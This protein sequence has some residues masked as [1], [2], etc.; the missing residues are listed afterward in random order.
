MAAVDGGGEK[1]IIGGIIAC[2]KP[3]NDV[4]ADRQL[5][6]AMEPTLTEAIHQDGMQEH[7]ARVQVGGTSIQGP[8]G[9]TEGEI[10]EAEE[11]AVEVVI[12]EEEVK[13]AVDYLGKILLSEISQCGS[14]VRGHEKGW[15]NPC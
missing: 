7:T 3:S 13:K 5:V 10:A 15:E 6:L 11:D 12:E 14:T 9:F 4:L 2:S 1:G 8:A